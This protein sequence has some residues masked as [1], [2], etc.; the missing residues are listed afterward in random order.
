MEV[1]D[2]MIGFLEDLSLLKLSEDEKPRLR[3]NLS[4]ILDGMEKFRGI[5]TETTA[6]CR[7]PVN[8]TNIFREDGVQPS[9]DRALILQNASEHNGEM[10]IAP[11]TIE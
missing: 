7:C 6:E 2:A 3:H 1:N 5:N 10:F 4:G 8:I 9:F 11:K